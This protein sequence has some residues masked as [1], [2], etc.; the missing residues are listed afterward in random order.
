MTP[1]LAV[2]DLT[3]EYPGVRALDGV[4]L[5][6]AP[7]EVHGVIGENG[8]G[9]STLM[10]V[11]AGLQRP[12]RG[13]LL[14]RGEPVRFASAAEAE[15][16]GVAMIHQELNLVDELSVA[17]NLTLGREPTRGPLVDRRR[18][19]A[20]AREWLAAVGFGDVDPR[21]RLGRLSVAR[22]Q[23]VEVAKAVGR[24]ADA[25]I[26]DEPTAVLGGRETEALLALVRRLRDEG[27]TVVYVSHRLAEVRAVCDRVSVLRDG[28]LVASVGRG[29]VA[30]TGEAELAS[31]MVG[32]ELGGQFPERPEPGEEVAF[33]CGGPIPL[34]VRAGE[35]VGLAG[36]IGAGRT[37]WAESVVGLRRP[38]TPFEVGG[39][40]VVARSVAEATA[41]GVAYVSEDCKAAGLHLSMPIAANSTLATL[42]NYCNPA[43]F[44]PIGVIDRKAIESVTLAHA[45]NLRTKFAR[46]RD[47]VSTLSGGNQQKVALAKWLDARPRV[48]VLDEPTRGV[49]VGAKREIYKVIVDLAAGGMA[50]VV[51][52]SELPE[53]LGLCGRIGVVRGGRLVEMV[54]GGEA[55]EERIMRAAAA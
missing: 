12:T 3:V 2:E 6:F 38:A 40:R 5:A 31:L 41:A 27:R 49:D 43:V 44:G 20:D 8:A 14:R 4:S 19:E 52:S 46:T 24:R 33:E 29:E 54:D 22:Q 13:R 45:A 16:A 51:V 10:K 21:R 53:L 30:G 15:G 50:C 32:R 25:I 34:R 18:A 48:L 28:R 39:R 1:A 23:G 42:R 55:T 35:I 7:G 36:L 37:E 17:E 47:P 26:M 9:K 11:L